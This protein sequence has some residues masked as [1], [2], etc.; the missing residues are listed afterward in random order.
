MPNFEI[1]KQRRESMA[2]ATHHDLW[3]IEILGLQASGIFHVSMCNTSEHANSELVDRT[4]DVHLRSTVY[5]YS[6][7]RASGF[8]TPSDPLSPESS[9]VEFL[10]SLAYSPLLLDL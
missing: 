4:A 7:H 6:R 3:L 8:F 2:Q 1:A 10:D 5:P 9:N